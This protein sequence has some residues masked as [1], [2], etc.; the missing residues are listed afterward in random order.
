MLIPICQ[1]C[2]TVALE[3]GLQLFYAAELLFVAQSLA[4]LYTGMLSV[5]IGVEVDYMRL[6]CLARAL[7]GWVGAYISH[8]LEPRTAVYAY[9]CGVY[10]VGRQQLAVAFGAQIG[11][12][13]VY[14]ASFGISVLHGS[15]Y[16]EAPS[17][18]CCSSAHVAL[19]KQSA[20]ERRRHT[21]VLHVNRCIVHHLD[22]HVLAVSHIVVE[23][24]G[25]VMAETVVITDEQSA[26]TQLTVQHLKHKV[27]SRQCCHTCVEVE[28]LDVVGTRKVEQS[29]FLVERC[30]ELRH[31]VGMHH[32]ARM[33][34]EGDYH[35]LQSDA[36]SHFVESVYE[37]LM[38]PM[39]AVEETY[40][41]RKRCVMFQ[42]IDVAEMFMSLNLV[43]PAVARCLVQS[44]Y[45][46]LLGSDA[47]GLAVV[48]EYRFGCIDACN[49]KSFVE[50]LHV[51]L[52]HVHLVR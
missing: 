5:Y 7:E 42:W 52:Y 6:Y 35:R 2:L 14:L 45:A 50:N 31:I 32:L 17:E 34:V 30:D 8:R 51:W 33:S 38:S 18:T 25:A 46:S 49:G 21:H 27:V 11:G 48:D 10:P 26:Y 28:H 24:F 36:V 13:E 44:A 29:Q 23:A 1:R 22:A 37:E 3:L 39:H 19:G 9:T 43:Q 40:S 47:V 15:F 41:R 16:F 20:H 12:R 4:E